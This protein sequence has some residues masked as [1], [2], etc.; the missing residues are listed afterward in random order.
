MARILC[1]PRHLVESKDKQR[2][3]PQNHH[4]SIM[5]VATLALLA[6]TTSQATAQN[7]GTTFLDRFT[8]K[9]EDDNRD[10]GF[11]D[12]A[13]PNWNQIACDEENQLD[14]CLGYTDK[15]HTARDWTIQ[16]NYCRWCPEGENRCSK[17][18]QSPIDLRREAGYEPGTHE[19]A[20]EC[21][22]ASDDEYEI[23]ASLW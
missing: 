5:K 16:K 12:Y 13:P 6:W 19:L 1:F 23:G 8:Y 15:W 9:D 11:I 22:G 14:A 2:R 7:D 18:H 3:T 10:D 4:C 17:H 21:I 20:N